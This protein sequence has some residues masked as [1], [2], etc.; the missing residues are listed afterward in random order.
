M[1]IKGTKNKI[2]VEG[3]LIFDNSEELKE[4]LLER[5]DHITPHKPVIVDLSR[6]EEID[7]SG[8]Q[9]LLSFFKTLQNLSVKFNVTNINKEMLDILNLSGLT[10]Y[11]R[12]EV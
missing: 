5:I 11:F 7:S 3:N 2:T 10:K 9:I 1:K 12:L 6:V 8:L 4:K